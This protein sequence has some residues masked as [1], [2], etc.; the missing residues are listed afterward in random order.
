M[1]LPYGAVSLRVSLADRA[2]LDKPSGRLIVETDHNV[3]T[4][5]PD[6]LRRHAKAILS[7]CDQAERLE[8]TGWPENFL[9]T[10]QDI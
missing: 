9:H 7:A 2:I 4:G 10:L 8:D 5:T 1:P 6:A 3:A